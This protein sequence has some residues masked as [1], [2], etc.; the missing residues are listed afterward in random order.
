MYYYFI[1]ELLR[2][3]FIEPVI[4]IRL[5]IAFVFISL[6]VLLTK[7]KPSLIK[8][9]LLLGGLIISLMS[10]AVNA[11]AR[12]SCYEPPPP[13]NSLYT[14]GLKY[15]AEENLF[16]INLTETGV[17]GFAIGNIEGDEVCY[18]LKDAESNVII[19]GTLKPKDGELNHR[20]F[21]VE[22][23]EIMLPD[24][25]QEGQYTLYIFIMEATDDDKKRL[26]TDPELT[27][28]KIV[29]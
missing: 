22:E 1:M 4:L 6:L 17:L 7:G 21:G 10:I 28:I 20:T 13:V 3:S 8:K 2:K 23:F 16:V 18:E 27:P 25:L 12:A 24:D 15:N 5:G 14:G 19:E 9:K 29:R 26:P 11:P